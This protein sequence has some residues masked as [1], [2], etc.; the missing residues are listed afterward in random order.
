MLNT[1]LEEAKQEVKFG[2]IKRK[3]PFRYPVLSSIEKNSPSQRTVVLR[4]TTTDFELIFYTD[5]RSNK[6]GD[7]KT[8]PNA[9][10]L[11]Y[12]PKKRL[13]IQVKGEMKLITSGKTYEDYWS[14]IQGASKKDF[15]T[16]KAPGSIITNPEDVEYAENENFFCVLKLVP[17]EIEYLQLKSPNRVR[18]LFTK[19][20]NWEG[21]FLNP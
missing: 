15:S 6:I 2:Y 8:N 5:L 12:H 21:C 3:H 13:Q 16:E 9:S 11:F 17:S 19:E 1:I 4:D 7:F 18:A 14:R 20:D 10:V